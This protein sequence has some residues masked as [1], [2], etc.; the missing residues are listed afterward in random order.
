MLIAVKNT[1]LANEEKQLKQ[2]NLESMWCKVQ[3]TGCKALYN[4]CLYRPPNSR[5]DPLTDLDKSLNTLLV[6][7]NLRNVHLS[8][9]FNL[10]SINWDISDNENKYS[11]GPTPQYGL[12]VNNLMTDIVQTYSLSQKVQKPTRGGIF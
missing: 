7:T 11:I 4:G 1:L 5:S 3:V 6:G 10:P 2:E 12:K 8:G 9:D